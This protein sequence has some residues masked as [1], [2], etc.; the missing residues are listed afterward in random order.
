MELEKIPFDRN[1]VIYLPEKKRKIV[2]KSSKTMDLYLED[3]VKA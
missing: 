3:E 2:R 1:I